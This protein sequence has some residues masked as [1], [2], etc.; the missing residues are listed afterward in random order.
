MVASLVTF[1]VVA[2][3]GTDAVK[4]A[5]IRKLAIGTWAC[6]PDVQDSDWSSFT[7]EVED[8]GRFT[9]VPDSK[10]EDVPV[11]FFPEI[12]G[13][14][15]IDD[16]DLKWTFDDVP[17]DRRFRVEGF[18]AL[19]PESESFTISD[20]GPFTSASPPD[21]DRQEILVDADGT[22]SVTMQMP[23]GEPWTCTR[24]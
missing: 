6:T 5:S 20:P 23:E 1:G 17:M 18:D 2:S 11:D 3:C 15:E 16:G 9:L 13:D 12:S 8:A 4:E 19:T 24:Q 21:P 14:W 10:P 22:D 7:L